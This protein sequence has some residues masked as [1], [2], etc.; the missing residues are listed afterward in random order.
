[1]RGSLGKK[2]TAISEE[3]TASLFEPEDKG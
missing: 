1:M 2:V 3:P